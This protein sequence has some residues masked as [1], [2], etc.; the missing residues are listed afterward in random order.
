MDD[1]CPEIASKFQ[2]LIMQKSGEQR[3]MMGFSM[4]DTARQ[5]VQSAIYNKH[6]DITESDLKKEIF[7][8]FYGLDFCR[9]DIEKVISSIG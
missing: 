7:V 1:T 2:D 3:L 8:R 4:Y 5:I 9:A 6:P